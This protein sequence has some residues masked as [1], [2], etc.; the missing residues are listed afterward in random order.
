MVKSGKVNISSFQVILKMAVIAITSG[1]GGVGKTTVSAN[2]AVALSGFAEVAVVDC[3]FV[4]PNLH[5]L[6]GI[7]SPP[8]SLMDVL[9]ENAEMS[10]AVYR[11]KARVGNYL[12][13]LLFV[14]TLSSPH[15][16]R[17][18]DEDRFREFI[19]FLERKSDVVVL[20]VSAGLSRLAVLSL[21]VADDICIVSNTDSFSLNTA[22]KILNVLN[23][24]DKWGRGIV[25]NRYSGERETVISTLRTLGIELKGVVR[26]S[27]LIPESWEAGVPVV[28]YK[29]KSG[30]AKDFIIM[31]EKILGIRNRIKPYGKLR[32]RFHW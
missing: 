20:D 8:V 25:F 29:P 13:S 10:E 24:L 4:L 18:F 15:L 2:L 22:S 9:S 26:E 21:S 28:S 23:D 3:D 6:F 7:D 32:L 14:P 1:K 31:A 27:E 30:V 17:N 5:L 19:R 12:T 16:L 11:L